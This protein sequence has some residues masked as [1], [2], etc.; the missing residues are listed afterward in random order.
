MSSVLFKMN[1][2]LNNAYICNLV[3]I[4]LHCVAFILL[5]KMELQT[6]KS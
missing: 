2:Y 5:E 3:Y 4:F 6:N 1:L